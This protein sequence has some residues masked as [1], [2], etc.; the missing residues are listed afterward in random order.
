MRFLHKLHEERLKEKENFSLHYIHIKWSFEK[1]STGKNK[2]ILGDL[3]LKWDEA[4]EDKWKHTKLQSPWIGSFT[5][6]ENICQ[7]TYHI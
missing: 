5:I 6:H 4:H 1:K 2:F 3:V 7:N